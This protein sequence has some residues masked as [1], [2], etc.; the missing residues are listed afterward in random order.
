MKAMH[1][2]LKRLKKDNSKHMF[3]LFFPSS[4]LQLVILAWKFH[5]DFKRFNQKEKRMRDKILDLFDVY[6][7][8]LKT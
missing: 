1:H 4:D 2:Y 5:V 3:G 8:H 7:A 6:T